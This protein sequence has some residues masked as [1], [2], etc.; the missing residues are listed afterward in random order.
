MNLIEYA[1]RTLGIE[2]RMTGQYGDLLTRPGK[3]VSFKWIAYLL[4]KVSLPQVF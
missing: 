2:L 3:R 4:N 1:K